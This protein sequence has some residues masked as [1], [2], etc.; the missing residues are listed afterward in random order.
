MI[1]AQLK[2]IA[3]SFILLSLILL[4][5]HRTDADLSDEA[6]IKNN[7]ITATTLSLSTQGTVNSN[8]IATLFNTPGFEPD[9]FD[10]ASIRIR[11]TGKMQTRY[12]LSV[13]KT[14]G[15]DSVCNAFNM[16]IMKNNS[17]LIESNLLST[18]LASEI[19]TSKQKED[20]V[21]FL[22]FDKDHG[23]LKN[24]SCSFEIQ[25]ATKDQI[26][27]GQKGFFDRRKTTNI[28]TTGL[29]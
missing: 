7:K 13:K 24:K 29:W 22:L 10:V 18:S 5:A 9:G 14:E 12:Y 27:D 23:F 16:K 19:L 20:L 3:W 4:T 1:K 26:A 25:I 8:I 28:I 21:L 11:N 15:E 6:Q 17:I 2:A